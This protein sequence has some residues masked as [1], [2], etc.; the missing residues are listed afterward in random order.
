MRMSNKQTYNTPYHHG[1]AG[2]M[3]GV[4]GGETPME[5]SQRKII[6]RRAAMELPGQWRRKPWN[7]HAGGRGSC[8]KRRK[9]H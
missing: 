2:R 1:F 6:A 9:H 7:W 3:R 8:C 5:M 4:V